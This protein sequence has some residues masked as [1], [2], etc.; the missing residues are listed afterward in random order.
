MGMAPA[1]PPAPAATP[2]PPVP[3][4]PQVP[5]YPGIAD[6]LQRSTTP[7]ATQAALGPAATAGGQAYLDATPAVDALQAAGPDIL[8]M[9]AQR[10]G[11]R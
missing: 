5:V 6:M 11:L 9:L 1:P 7:A 4:M 3:G 2:A 8:M 10:F